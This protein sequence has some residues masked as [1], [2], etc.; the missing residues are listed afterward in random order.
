MM[1]I[2]NLTV[3]SYAKSCWFHFDRQKSI[4][5]GFWSCTSMK[6]YHDNQFCISVL[7]PDILFHDMKPDI[8][9]MK[10]HF[11]ADIKEGQIYVH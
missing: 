2:L 6:A 9:R 11:L 3:F 1:K 4:Y 8:Q 7:N 5:L 10:A